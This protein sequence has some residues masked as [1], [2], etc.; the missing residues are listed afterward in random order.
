M[1]AQVSQWS[2]RACQISGFRLQKSLYP[3]L[4]YYRT[5]RKAPNLEGVHLSD[6]PCIFLVGCWCFGGNRGPGMLFWCEGRWVDSAAHTRA[7]PSCHFEL[8]CG[9]KTDSSSPFEHLCADGQAGANMQRLQAQCYEVRILVVAVQLGFCPC[10]H[11]IC[12][13][14]HKSLSRNEAARRAARRF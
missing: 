1:W 8:F 7:G 13:V 5:Q 2:H 10:P 3:C 4:R 14:S 6:P 11:M 12:W 9:S